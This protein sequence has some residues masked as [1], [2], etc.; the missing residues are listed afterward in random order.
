VAS[1]R[2]TGTLA[3]DNSGGRKVRK[4]LRALLVKKL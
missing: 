2:E 4:K 3:E 1:R